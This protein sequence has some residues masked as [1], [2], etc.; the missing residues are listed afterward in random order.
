MGLKTGSEHFLFSS[1]ANPCPCCPCCPNLPVAYLCCSL[2]PYPGT[3][4]LHLVLCQTSSPSSTSSTV[5]SSL[6]VQEQPP[7][8]ADQGCRWDYM[9]MQRIVP[10][11]C[12]AAPL[13]PYT[14][15]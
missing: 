1:S 9:A 2:S 10:L 12:D 15:L 14:G 7:R 11:L 5:S 4:S 13:L 6:S 3:L 8:L